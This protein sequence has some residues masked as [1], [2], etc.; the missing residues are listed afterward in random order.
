M[1]NQ[2]LADRIRPKCLDDIIGQQHLVGRNGILRR[3]IE[4][5]RISNMIFYGPPGVGKTTVASILAK[6]SG[7]SFYNLNATT[8]SLA[9]VKEIA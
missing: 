9:D 5:T 3:M 6:A 2:P 1:Q 4:K 8:A 7:M